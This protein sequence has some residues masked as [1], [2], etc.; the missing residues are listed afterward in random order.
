[1]K[2][3]TVLFGLYGVYGVLSATAIILLRA[4]GAGLSWPVKPEQLT[5]NLVGPLVLA[6]CLYAVSFG[7]WALI[8]TRSAVSVAYPVCFGL[9]LALSVAMASA[10]LGEQLSVARIAGIFLILAGVIV[11]SR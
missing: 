6:G 9:T 3:A 5:V 11:L 10:F 8:L 7:L 1:M 2:S 4:S